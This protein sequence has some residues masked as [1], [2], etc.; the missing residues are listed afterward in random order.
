MKGKKKKMP[1]TEVR[2]LMGKQDEATLKS[3]R[4]ILVYTSKYFIKFRV[5]KSMLE[6]LYF[7]KKSI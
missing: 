1:S 3:T 5:N 4:R 6:Q 2:K 7:K